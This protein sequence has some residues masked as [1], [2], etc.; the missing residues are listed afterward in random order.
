MISISQSTYNSKLLGLFV[1]DKS[2]SP[3]VK[4]YKSKIFYFDKFQ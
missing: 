2:W 1:N 3:I 4:I